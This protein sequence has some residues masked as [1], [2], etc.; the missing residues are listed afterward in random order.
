MKTKRK[1]FTA[2]LVAFA[3]LA[4]MVVNASAEVGWVQQSVVRIHVG[5]IP[6]I[7][8]DEYAV[9]DVCQGCKYCGAE[10]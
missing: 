2:M 9:G 5:A 3:V 6:L 8:A 7:D 4:V 10:I 1:S